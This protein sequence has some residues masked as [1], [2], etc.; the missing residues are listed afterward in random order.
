MPSTVETVGAPML[1]KLGDV[2]LFCGD[3]RATPAGADCAKQ[4]LTEFAAANGATEQRQI[5]VGHAVYD[6]VSA[7]AESASEDVLINICADVEHGSLE[8]V[9]SGPDSE[10]EGPADLRLDLR[11]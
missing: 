7:Y 1:A 3:V 2:M 11:S 9:I 5:E 6:A 8:F 4:W 10:F